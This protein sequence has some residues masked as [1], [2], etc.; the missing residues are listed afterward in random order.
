MEFDYKSYMSFKTNTIRKFKTVFMVS[1]FENWISYFTRDKD[2][3]N[4]FVK[5]LPSNLDYKSDAIRRK[6][7]DGITYDLQLNEWME[8][9]LFFGIKNED[10][11]PLF[12][13][14]QQGFLILDVGVN[15]GETLLNFAKLTGNTG[16]VYGFEPMPFT[17]KKC[18]HNVGLNDF[19]N[20]V[21]ENLALSNS[22]E[23]LV[24]NDP[25]N[26]NSGGTYVSKITV[27]AENKITI[28][29]IT[30]DDYVIEKDLKKIDFI[31]IDVEGYETNVL[32]GA[33]NVIQKF[34]PI[35]YIEVCDENLKRAG[36]SAIALMELLLNN[37]YQIRKSDNGVLLDSNS[38]KQYRHL[39][40][41]C[42]Y[43][44]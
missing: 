19:K 37:N 21:V 30:L 32:L 14:I 22:M 15:F 29:A 24:I 41:L 8:Y 26:G 12:K 31:K 44:G 42:T 10:K 39:D 18:R 40:V 3:N 28:N 6:T 38:I 7:V 17:Y 23:K 9:A 5:L 16:T 20:I 36:S 13:N 33:L 11:T 35:L 4:F 1:P 43:C 27:A 2:I 34:K 25:L